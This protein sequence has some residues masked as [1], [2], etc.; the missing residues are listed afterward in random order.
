MAVPRTTATVTDEAVMPISASGGRWDNTTPSTW[1][2]KNKNKNKNKNAR[3]IAWQQGWRASNGNGDEDGNGD[4]NKGD[5]HAMA[6]AMK[7]LMAMAR[8]VAGDKERNGK[9][10]KSDGKGDKVDRQAIAMRAMTTAMAT[11]RRW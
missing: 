7:W 11:C 10:G 8:R 1:S 3:A 9:G 5:G 2:M 4:G 6:A